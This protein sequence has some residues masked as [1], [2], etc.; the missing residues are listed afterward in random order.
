MI[1]L[2]YVSVSTLT[3]EEASLEII[4]IVEGAIGRNASMDVTGALLFTGTHFA[5]ALEGTEASVE[6]LM[7]SIRQD[8]RHSHVTIVDRH[9]IA[10][11]RFARWQMAYHGDAGYV[12]HPITRLLSQP[13]SNA[14]SYVDQIYA[15]MTEFVETPESSAARQSQNTHLKST[16]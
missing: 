13:R 5:Q 14:A 12:D 16:H 15:I 6:D 3:G 1:T 9:K 11:R 7:K 10:C 8:K 2:M 4:R